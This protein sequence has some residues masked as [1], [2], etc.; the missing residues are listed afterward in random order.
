MGRHR[1]IDDA[2]LLGVARQVFAERGHAATTRDVARAA[3]ISQAVLYQRFASKEALFFAA[4]APPPPDF[5]ALLGDAAMAGEDTEEYLV[6]IATRVLGYFAEA[7]PALLHLITHPAFTTNQQVLADTHEH[8]L[9][10]PLITALTERVQL[11]QQRALLTEA[12]DAHAAAAT[13]V[14]AIHSTALHAVIARV[15]GVPTEADIR[16]FVRVFWHGLAPQQGV[17]M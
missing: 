11:L 9:A 17:N 13:F 3:G 5:A 12:V 6:G 10:A 16:R 15:H 14:A 7:M 4:L 2:A 8:I 1:T